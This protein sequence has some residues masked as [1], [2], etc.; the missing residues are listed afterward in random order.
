[1]PKPHD[2]VLTHS[3]RE[4]L[5]A[6]ALWLAALIYTVGYCTLYGYLGNEG[7][8]HFLFGIPT[9]VMW[10]IVAPWTVMLVASAW[11]AFSFMTDDSL[12]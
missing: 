6:L 4:A 11:F 2:P 5:V 8:L 9:W 1:M 3:R 10:G 7:E 12:E